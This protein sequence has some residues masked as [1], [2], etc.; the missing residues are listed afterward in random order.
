MYPFLK[1]ASWRWDPESKEECETVKLV[2]HLAVL[3]WCGLLGMEID[4]LQANHRYRLAC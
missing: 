4:D 2:L 3:V 1:L